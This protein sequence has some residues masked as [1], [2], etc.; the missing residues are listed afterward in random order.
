[1]GNHSTQM[2]QNS[3]FLT[4]LA[5]FGLLSIFGC[6][7]SKTGLVMTTPSGLEY[8]DHVIGTGPQPAT[9]QNVTVNYTGMLTDADSTKFDSNVDPKFRHV[10]PFTFK[11]GV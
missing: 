3:R 8:V 1:M 9:G 11:L 7:S 6:S 2:H 4:I 10:E 5:I